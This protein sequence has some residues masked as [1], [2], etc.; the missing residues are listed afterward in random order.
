MSDDFEAR[1]SAARDRLSH[2]AQDGRTIDERHAF[3]EAVYEGAHHDPAAVPWAELQPKP[4][5]ADWL[6]RLPEGER[7]GRAVD[8]ACGLGDNAVALADAGF[9]TVGF[10]FAEH[11][12]SWAR[13]RFP[14]AGVHFRLAD[15]FNPPAEWVGAFDLVHECYTIQ[16]FQDDLRQAAFSAVADLIAPGGR[17]LVIARTRPED[18]PPAGPPVPLTPSELARFEDLG[19][20]RVW[21]ED[22]VVTRPDKTIPHTIS[23]YQKEK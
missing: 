16:S 13:E 4:A 1:R 21:S 7:Q 17:L 19:L 18:A 15:L 22:Y 14:K 12:I 5:L 3:F 10:D 9:T 8:V 20:T 11:A 2:E 6:S 23:E